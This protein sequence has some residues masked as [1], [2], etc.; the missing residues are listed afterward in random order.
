MKLYRLTK[1]FFG[2]DGKLHSRG[3]ELLL[4]DGCAPKSAIEI[5]GHTP[6]KKKAEA[7]DPEA[8]TD[9]IDIVDVQPGDTLSSLTKKKK[10]KA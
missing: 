1:N 9:A 4:A 7:V 5:G 6:V 2:Q 10:G 8:V 3:T